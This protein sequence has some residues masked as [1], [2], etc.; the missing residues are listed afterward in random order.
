MV[1]DTKRKSL[2]FVSGARRPKAGNSFAVDYNTT[3]MYSFANPSAGWVPKDPIPYSANHMSSV[4]G[5]DDTGKE[6]HFFLGG[7]TSNNECC[8]NHKENYEFDAEN[9]K[10][11][12]R[13]DMLVTRGHA[14]SSTRPI[15]CG[16]II[17]A[18][19]TNESGKT[20]DVSYYNIA[21]DTWTSIG[22]IPNAI[23]TPI[24][25]LRGGYM[26]CESGYVN[27]PFSYRRQ[28]TV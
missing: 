8:G 6:R 25:D 23:N 14:S 17:A 18:G 21:T 13:A 24:C 11:I 28:I 4:T 15:S 10:W 1:Y 3:W 16:F 2:F 9:E 7:Q 19:T 22:N 12:K 5:I 26:Y 20:S 27:G